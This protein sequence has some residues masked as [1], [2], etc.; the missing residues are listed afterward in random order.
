[1]KPVVSHFLKLGAA[2]GLAALLSSCASI[3]A[4]K[5]PL[6]IHVV[7]FNDFHGN[8]EAPASVPLPDPEHPGQT[9]PAG[10]GGAARF[11]TLSRQL[12][13]RPNSIMVAAGDLIG[14]S[15]LLSGLFHDEPT[16]ESLSVMGLAITSVGNHEFDEGV[17]EL[18]RMQDGGCHPK[19]GCKSGHTFKGAKYH[20]LSA[21]AIET[22]KNATVF[23]ASEVRTFEGVKVGFIGLSLRGVP[24][25]LAPPARQG[26]AFLD[27]AETVNKEAARLKAQGVEAIVVLIHEGG[28]PARQ[29]DPCKG[30]SGPIT[31]IVPKLDKAVDVVVSGHTHESYVCTIDGRLVTSAGRY[32]VMLTDMTLTID[33]TTRDIT[34][35]EAHNVV[36]RKELLEDPKINKLLAPYKALADGIINRIVGRLDAPLPETL[37]DNAES[38][39]GHVIADSFL[40][41]AKKAAGGPV[42]IALMNPGGVRTALPS[43]N[44]QVKYSDLYTVEP[45]GNTLVV[46]SLTG[47]EIEALLA[48]QFPA[49]GGER[50]ILH[51]S[52]GFGF[53]WKLDASGKGAVV[54]GSVMLNGQ[55]LVAAKTYR[56]VTNNFLAS[57]GD[58]FTAFRAGQD[59]I[60]AGNDVDA[61][62]A[63]FGAH[64]PVKAPAGGRVVRDK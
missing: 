63:Y 27:E 6:E 11:S 4:P 59:E 62:E 45:F 49:D 50:K 29:G 51:V 30:I 61:L 58:G 39:L 54:P 53:H 1:M 40:E 47:A 25:L 18:H 46:M 57:G 12:L 13:Q 37:D 23:P 52:Q 36:V 5:G 64:T 48:Q 34:R 32:S 35:A 41:A 20:Y 60:S 10:S 24:A 15:P 16:V 2:A 33:R 28:F 42:D 3:G 17:E 31:Q 56:V 8:L 26:L 43:S 9:V 14:A 44:G 7:A 21:N 22:A 38:A 19:D 55:L